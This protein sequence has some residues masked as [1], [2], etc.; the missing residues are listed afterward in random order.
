[1]NLRVGG[2]TPKPLLDDGREKQRQMKNGVGVWCLKKLS[3]LNLNKKY[4][5]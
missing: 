1:M 2:L 5:Y 4:G 3:M